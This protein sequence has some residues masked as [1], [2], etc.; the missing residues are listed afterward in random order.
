MGDYIF[1]RI[2]Q[3]ETVTFSS[4]QIQ[5]FQ[6]GRHSGLPQHYIWIQPDS[7]LYPISTNA[8]S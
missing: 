1:V 5:Y 3:N 2:E 6:Q 4:T 7:L 8:F